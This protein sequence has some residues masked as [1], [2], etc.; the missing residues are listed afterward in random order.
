MNKPT[1]CSKMMGL[2]EQTAGWD[3]IGYMARAKSPEK[4]TAILEAAVQEIAA[5]GLGASTARIAKAAG[6]AEGTMFR[7]FSSKD[8]LLNELYVELKTEV[9]GRIDEGFPHGSGLR[10]RA[11]HIWTE[12]LRWALQKPAE[13]KVSVLLHLSGV[14]TAATREKMSAQ[15]GAMVR[16]MQERGERGTF[17]GLP[18]GFATAA[19][20]AMQEAV[21]E[22]AAKKPK[23]AAALVEQ[24]FDCFWKMAR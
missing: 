17:K 11:R 1:L 22:M 4:R 16:T 10:E 20:V 9:H 8:E 3:S 15:R 18:A 5:A 23:Q 24:A 21:M 14:V 12:Y 7:Y 19:M 13:R 6:L 2:A